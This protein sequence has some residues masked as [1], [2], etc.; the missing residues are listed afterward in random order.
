[1]LIRRKSV[2]L[3]LAWLVSLLFTNS[4]AGNPV[5]HDST[6]P[7]QDVENELK[8]I[9][10]QV[11]LNDTVPVKME[12]NKTLL[13]RLKTV[14]QREDSY[15]YAFDSLETISKLAP[16]DKS[17][18]IFTWLMRD[19]KGY[20][21]YYGLI[22]RRFI[23]KDGKAKITVIQLEDNV[24]KDHTLET[25]ILDNGRWFGAL[26]YQPKLETAGIQ[27]YDGVHSY[28][29]KKLKKRVTEKV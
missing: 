19:K 21:V 27:S 12:F 23:S 13:E 15:D 11:L 14:L 28:Y 3:V 9:A 5:L 6:A 25:S 16:A 24:E 18:R 20:H 26:Y 1:M 8:L 29:D 22:Q 10:R 17:F 2:F 4:F 7:L